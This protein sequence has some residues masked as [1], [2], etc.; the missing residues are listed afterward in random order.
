M[1]LKE[2]LELKLAKKVEMKSGRTDRHLIISIS[3]IST[4]SFV[5][6]Y[7]YSPI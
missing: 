3:P 5:S 2:G 6:Y 4:S 1:E 7:W